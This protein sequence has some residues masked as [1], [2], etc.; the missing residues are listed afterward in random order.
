MAQQVIHTGETR[1]LV[2]VNEAEVNLHFVQEA[3]SVLRLHV[4]D[5]ES[6]KNDIVVEQAGE[7]CVTEICALACVG[8]KKEVETRTHVFHNVGG[9]CSKQLVKFV[10]SD[11]ARGEF[12]GELK[13]AKDAQKTE[14]LQTNRN[15]LLSE[16]A[17]MRTRPQLEIYADDVR[18]SHG[19]TT[20][21]LDESA[22]FYMQQ[23]CLSEEQG[24]RLLLVAFM[25]DVIDTIADE[26]KRNEILERLESLL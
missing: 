13:I 20:G 12:Y 21:Q 4:I 15:L 22:L 19:A 14:A 9:G 16:K 8:G 7:G 6:A 5:W 25:A 26:E 2:L 11:E 17:L 3:G 24:R 23:R 1:D 18:A 10:L